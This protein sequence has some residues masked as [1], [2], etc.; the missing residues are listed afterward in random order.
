MVEGLSYKSEKEKVLLYKT[1]T[2][3]IPEK[4]V[5]AW[6]EFG[7]EYAQK[8]N[9]GTGSDASKWEVPCIISGEFPRFGVLLWQYANRNGN[10]GKI[11]VIP[12]YE[13]ILKVQKKIGELPGC[14]PTDWKSGMVSPLH[15]HPKLLYRGKDF[16][17]S[18]VGTRNS[19]EGK[20]Y[21]V[22]EMSKDGEKARSLILSQ[23]NAD[24]RAQS[25]FD[26]TSGLEVASFVRE[27]AIIDLANKKG[28][29]YP[30]A[31][32]ENSLDSYAKEIN[33][34]KLYELNDGE[35][36]TI[37]TGKQEQFVG[38]T[39]DPI[40][41]GGQGEDNL[42]KYGVKLP[43]KPGVNIP[44][45]FRNL[46]EL[47]KGEVSPPVDWHWFIAGEKTAAMGEIAGMP[48]L[49]LGSVDAGDIFYRENYPEEDPLF[50]EFARTKVLEGH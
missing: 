43:G 2:G 18:V 21:R 30:L 15:S 4:V 50:L 17:G 13:D 22:R 33:F 10:C 5:R 37:R 9:L 28:S 12:G 29:G 11:A 14:E 19:L 23:V 41:S 35:I 36:F 7:A 20:I 16:V 48:H 8:Q 45:G 27:E 38:L 34:K 25:L 49:G 6:Q 3:D 42:Q 1:K 40:L 31:I 44:N 32:T 47:K 46:T 26:L 24:Q 39:D